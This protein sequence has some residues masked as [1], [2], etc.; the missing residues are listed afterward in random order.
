MNSPHFV[1]AV[2][3]RRAL[4]FA[5][6]CLES[7]RWQVGSYKIDLVYRDDASGYSANELKRLRDLVEG[8]GGTLIV[9]SERLFQ[10]GSLDS[11]IRHVGTPQSV[12]CELDG[13]DYLLPHAIRTVAEA[14]A[15]PNVAATYGNVLVD[16]RPF[17]DLQYFGRDK[18]CTNTIY[19]EEVW[20]SGTFRRDEFRC[21]HLRTF[22]RWLWD[23]IDPAHF[24][25]PDGSFFRGSGDSAFMFPI[26][27]MLADPRHV[28]FI[29]EPI[30]V[31]RLHDQN[32]W[33]VDKP[34]QA[35]DFAY[36]RGELQPY[37]P[38]DRE[39]LK[40]LLAAGMD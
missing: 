33:R 26:L 1:I 14:Y 16:F 31:Y 11:V 2:T 5:E 35:N 29:D 39:L 13:D 27:E 38:L 12:I 37:A 28:R 40:T 19:P 36:I 32:V 20:S 17:Q 10:I 3:A 22:R 23:R 8:A 30:Y 25:R 6:R 15:D 9:G 21:F 18:C 24:R 7:V 34:S 4:R